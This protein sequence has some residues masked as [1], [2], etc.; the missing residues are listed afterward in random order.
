MPTDWS[1]AV[2]AA[3][4]VLAANPEL[5]DDEAVARLAERGVD[6]RDARVAVTMLPIAFGRVLLSERGVTRHSGVFHVQDEGG[7][8]V[9]FEFALQPAFVEA[10]QLAVTARH[11]GTIDRH[12]FHQIGARSVEVER[13]EAGPV[14]LLDVEP[15]MFVRSRPWWKF[16]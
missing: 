8:W 5:E 12:A 6:G 1:R 2:H 7:N 13:S 11:R 16:W 15:D 10:T 9:A 3:A 4:E 14:A